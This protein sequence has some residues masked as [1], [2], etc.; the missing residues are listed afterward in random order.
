MAPDTI[1]PKRRRANPS[2]QLQ[3]S[4]R[5]FGRLT[6]I[7]K[8][9]KRVNK[10]VMWLCQCMCGRQAIVASSKLVNGH[11][12]SCGC[13]RAETLR[14]HGMSRQKEFRVWLAMLDRCM[15]PDNR[16]YFRY[17]GRGIAVCERWK[18]YEHFLADMGPL[19][20]GYEIDRI[21]NDGN[22]EPDNCQWST[23][24]QQS[25]NR[26][27]NRMLTFGGETMCVASWAERI[28]IRPSHLHSRLTLG[29]SIEKTLTQ[30]VR[31]RRWGRKPNA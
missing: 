26:S 28:G 31:Q 13:L 18:T 9:D 3:L 1:S 7:S 29:W 22:Y 15:N 17:G 19:P 21:D 8:T 27:N 20:T 30:P 5:T 12:K 2:G 6:A 10:N 4:G 23:D 25:R 11:T 16:G 24:K 14:T